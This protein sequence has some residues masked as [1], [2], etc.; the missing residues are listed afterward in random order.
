MK[1]RLAI[2]ALALASAP[3]LAQDAGGDAAEGEKVFRQCIACHVVQNDAGEL[4]AGRAGKT[5]PN[6]FGII[7]R[8]AGSVEGFRYS[9]VMHE[10]GE[11]GLVWSEETLVPYLHDPTA[12]LRET[13]GDDKARSNMTLKL[14]TEQQAKDVYAY[15]ASLMPA[16]N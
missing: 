11:A 14:R 9:K 3:A 12:F 4:L 5:G 15:L 10:A 16:A 2:V 8:H 13:S 1:I 6:L 7:G